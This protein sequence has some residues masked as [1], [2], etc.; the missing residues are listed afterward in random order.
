LIELAG[1]PSPI[2]ASSTSKAIN[3]LEGESSEHT[4]VNALN[5]EDMARY[6]ATPRVQSTRK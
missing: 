2:N 4:D 5:A 6:L 1:L 3:D